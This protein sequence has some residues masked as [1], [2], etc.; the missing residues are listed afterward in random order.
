MQTPRNPVSGQLAVLTLNSILTIVLVVA[1]GVSW[2]QHSQRALLLLADR[3]L[4]RHGEYQRYDNPVQQWNFEA[5]NYNL[6]P[7]L[8]SSQSSAVSSPFLRSL[9]QQAKAARIMVLPAL[10]FAVC[11][12]VLHLWAWKQHTAAVREHGEA[13]PPYDEVAWKQ[14]D[15]EAQ[16]EDRS[17]VSP[18]DP[19]NPFADSRSA[20]VEMSGDHKTR[21]G[22]SKDSTVPEMAGDG[23]YGELDGGVAAAE[24]PA[25]DQV[26]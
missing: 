26:R 15:L 8:R 16:G 20:A 3:Y 17:P 19:V 12:L 6:A 21:A 9:C 5:W 18:M 10:I 23:G 24:K 4:S 11:A 14:A 22:S 13:A 25:M 7:R 2:Y 1:T